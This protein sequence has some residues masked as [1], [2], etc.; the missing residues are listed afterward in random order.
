MLI[1]ALW[2]CEM[3]NSGQEYCTV[4]RYSKAHNKVN[5]DY[6]FIT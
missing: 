2:T 4:D 1:L 3:G 5:V 6:C